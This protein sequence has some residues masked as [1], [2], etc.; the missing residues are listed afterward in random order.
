MEAIYIK[1]T[2]DSDYLEHHGIKGQRWGVR[3]YQNSDGSLTAAGQKRI[4]KLQKGVAKWTK[5]QAEYE[6]KKYKAMKG[7]SSH[8]KEKKLM[9][10]S[11]KSAKALKKQAKLEKKLYKFQKM[12]LKTVKKHQK[13]KGRDAVNAALGVA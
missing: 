7:L 13:Q 1:M 3:R 10:Y 4:T 6:K 5:K 12:Q 2:D 8:S 9:K 11:K